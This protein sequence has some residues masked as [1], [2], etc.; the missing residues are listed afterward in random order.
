MRKHSFG[1]KSLRLRARDSP[2]NF[3]PKVRARLEDIRPRASPL[4]RYKSGSLFQQYSGGCN[5]KGDERVHGYSLKMVDDLSLASDL[6]HKWTKSVPVFGIG[7]TGLRAVSVS[8]NNY[9]VFRCLTSNLHCQ[10]ALHL[11]SIRKSNCVSRI[12]L[13]PR[14]S[15]ECNA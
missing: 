7:N 6:F 15:M 4:L 10:V 2:V 12:P 9:I 8:D 3:P 11:P 5:A 13:R 14:T 1:F